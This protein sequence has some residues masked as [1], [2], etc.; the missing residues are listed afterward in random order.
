MK[1]ITLFALLVLSAAMLTAQT[2]PAATPKPTPISATVA[3]QAHPPVRQ[4]PPEVP[5]VLKYKVIKAKSQADAAQLAFEHSAAY[6]AFT[7]AQARAAAF[8]AVVQEFQKFCGD[9]FNPT[10][11]SGGE[12]VCVAKPAQPPAPAPPAPPTA[13]P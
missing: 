5:A 8:A 11:D 12:P 1:H 4:T 2:K 10:L 3:P 7:E 6:P 13:K 9:N